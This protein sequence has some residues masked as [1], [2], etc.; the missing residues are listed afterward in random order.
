[1][2]STSPR[3]GVPALLGAVFNSSEPLGNLAAGA[4]GGAAPP[5][6]AREPA[7]GA[8]GGG[9]GR[10]E[11][12]GAGRGRQWAGPPRGGDWPSRAA[13]AASAAL[14]PQA[15]SPRTAASLRPLVS[16]SPRLVSA[17]RLPQ[18]DAQGERGRGRGQHAHRTLRPLPGALAAEAQPA[19]GER[20]PWVPGARGA[21]PGIGRTACWG[22][23]SVCGPGPGGACPRGRGVL[24]P[25]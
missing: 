9:R 21:E 13:S 22:T 6:G 17:S 11:G 18:D 23:S 20:A 14:A 8:A 5:G 7:P 4:L 15:P 3:P 16:T 1:M 2:R 25:G 12:R 19:R 24:S 10:G